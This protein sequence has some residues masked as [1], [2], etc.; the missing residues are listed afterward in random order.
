MRAQAAT[1]YILVSSIAFLVIVPSTFFFFQFSQS[2]NRA[3]ESTQI[4][5]IGDRLALTTQTVFNGGLGTRTT[6]TD[7][8]PE[9]IINITFEPAPDDAF[10][11]PVPGG[12]YVIYYDPEFSG[13]PLIYGFPVNVP[14]SLDT[15]SIEWGAG[16]RQLRF[17]VLQDPAAPIDERFYVNL[18][19]I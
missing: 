4:L 11:N 15:A 2:Q 14:V 3:F 16:Q 9:G 7:R 10:G 19:V 6:I 1:E 18:T 8:F 5:R 17:D 12:E 13:Q